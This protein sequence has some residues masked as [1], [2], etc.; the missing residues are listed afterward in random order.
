MGL[1]SFEDMIKDEK[2]SHKD[3]HFMLV[4]GMSK[5]MTEDIKS[6][7]SSDFHVFGLKWSFCIRS[8]VKKDYLS[9]SMKISDE[10]SFGSNWEVR[11]RVKYSA[12]T[13]SGQYR[14][15][16]LYSASYNANNKMWEHETFISYKVLKEKC[17]VNDKAVFFAEISDVKLKSLDHVT[18]TPRAI[19]TA[20]RIKL[21]EVPQ[22]KSKFTWKITRFSSFRGKGPT[23]YEFTVEQRKWLVVMC[24]KGD[25]QTDQHLSL[26]LNACDYVTNAPKG[27]T[28][29][30]FKM[31]L[32]DQRK[33]NHYEKQ[34]EYW[35]PYDPPTGSASGWSKFL[36]LEKLHDASNGYLVNDHL[37]ITVEFLFVSTTE[38]L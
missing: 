10:K 7:Q 12:V 33:G 36:P 23:S 32:F 29:A 20:E 28:L 6:C 9:F 3:A 21:M 35:F 25:M 37:Y 18:S 24:P 26:F 4:D 13:Q 1:T 30:V 16:K 5:L 27:P 31:R 17:L 38:K 15:W 22:N 19:G 8:D 11:C 2:N 34:N 14:S